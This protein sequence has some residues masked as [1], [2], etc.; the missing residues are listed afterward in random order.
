MLEKF[1]GAEH[2]FKGISENK[3]DPKVTPQENL[4]SLR[5][6]FLLFGINI[7]PSSHIA[8]STLKTLIEYVNQVMSPDKGFSPLSEILLRGA[9]TTESGQRIGS[10]LIESK[11]KK[12]LNIQIAAGVTVGEHVSF[13]TSVSICEQTN[14]EDNVVINTGT[15]IGKHCS[16]GRGAFFGL[17]SVIGDNVSIEAFTVLKSNTKVP[18]HSQVVHESNNSKMAKIQRKF[19]IV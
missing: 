4:K 13:G 16:V 17:D 14:I 1:T 11:D 18:N 7:D 2:I 5:E 8:N 19:K 3:Y 10:D 6:D 9:K 12:D 15:A